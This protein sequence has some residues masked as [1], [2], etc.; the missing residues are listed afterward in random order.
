M[1]KSKRETAI[2]NRKMA[3]RAAATAVHHVN[4]RA[5]REARARQE[6]A[7][8]AARRAAYDVARALPPTSLY[9]KY[10][11]LSPGYSETRQWLAFEWHERLAARAVGM[12]ESQWLADPVQN[13]R[14]EAAIAAKMT[15]DRW[16]GYV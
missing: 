7:E 12:T 4:A 5:V 14:L 1:N 10:A 9:E 11:L 16:I 15:V 6:I 2:Q 13:A 3:E 8:E